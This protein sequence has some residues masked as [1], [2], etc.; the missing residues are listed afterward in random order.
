MS[1]FPQPAPNTPETRA[2]QHEVLGEHLAGISFIGG[3][4]LA[5]I[6]IAPADDDEDDPP[7]TGGAPAKQAEPRGEERDGT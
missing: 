2:R 1:D 7:S 4:T 6:P 5:D 3:K